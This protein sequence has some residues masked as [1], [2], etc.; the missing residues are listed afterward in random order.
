M[1]CAIMECAMSYSYFTWQEIWR[2]SI[3]LFKVHWNDHLVSYFSLM[4]RYGINKKILFL[5]FSGRIL[6]ISYKMLTITGVS[7]EKRNKLTIYAIFSRN[8]TIFYQIELASLFQV[9][10][11]LI[12]RRNSRWNFSSSCLQMTVI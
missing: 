2:T 5:T 12:T 3:H 8:V 6:I 9:Q 10:E 7:N 1:E 4:Y 11:K